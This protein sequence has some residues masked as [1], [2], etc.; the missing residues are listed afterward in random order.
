MF[1]G[2]KRRFLKKE[3][4]AIISDNLAGLVLGNFV[5]LVVFCGM[6]ALELMYFSLFASYFP[7]T[8]II[9]VF[10]A[11][12]IATLVF[13]CP[14]IYG[15]ICWFS[16]CFREKRVSPMTG[17]FRCYSDIRSIRRALQVMIFYVLLALITAALVSL[18]VFIGVKLPTFF[19]G[20]DYAQLVTT[21]SSVAASVIS[22]MIILHSFSA[23]CVLKEFE[24]NERLGIFDAFKKSRAVMR[25]HKLEFLLFNLSFLPLSALSVFTFGILFAVYTIPYYIM[26][27]VAYTGYLCEEYEARDTDRLKTEEIMAD[28]TQTI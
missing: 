18:T 24:Q 12:E 6:F 13:L 25:G 17:I 1:Y 4:S 16:D 11:V 28:N 20:H 15:W 19:I 26:S 21:L 7:E 9:P 5:T 22:L 2:D 27:V 14:L 8:V 10:V 23:L 3:A